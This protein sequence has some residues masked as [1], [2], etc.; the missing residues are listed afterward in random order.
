MEDNEK[1]KKYTKRVAGDDAGICVVSPFCVV[2]CV[3]DLLYVTAC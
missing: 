1:K 2:L 3:A